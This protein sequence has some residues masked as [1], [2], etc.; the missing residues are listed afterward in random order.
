MTPFRTA[1]VWLASRPRVYRLIQS[2][3]GQARVASRLKRSLPVLPADAVLLDL[4]SAEGSFA[5]HLGLDPVFTDIDLR[6]LL[7]LRTRRTRCRAVAADAAALPFR[8]AEFDA[9]LC[10]AVAHHLDD[11]SLARVAGELARVTRGY[12]VFLD[13]VRNERRTAS[14]WLW[15]YDRGRYPRT[16]RELEAVLGRRFALEKRDEFSILHQYVSWIARPLRQRPG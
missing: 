5:S 4:G 9:S 7:A 14:R 16:R 6:P 11:G 10:V 12:L 1:A 2:L 15:R 8:D 3:A 13:P